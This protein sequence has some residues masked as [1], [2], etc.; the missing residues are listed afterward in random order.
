V[1][2]KSLAVHR[3]F[4]QMAA[5]LIPSLIENDG[6]PTRKA[7]VIGTVIVSSSGRESGRIAR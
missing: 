4:R 5:Y 6:T 1:P 7:E 3:P 2:V